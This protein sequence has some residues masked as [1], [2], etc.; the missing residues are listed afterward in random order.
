MPE[1]TGKSV[2]EIGY[3]LMGTRPLVLWEELPR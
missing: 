1:L 3:G 2:G